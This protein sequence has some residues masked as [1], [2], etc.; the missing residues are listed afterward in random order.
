MSLTI[1]NNYAEAPYSEKTCRREVRY[2]SGDMNG[3]ARKYS[4]LPL[5]IDTTVTKRR[6]S[7]QGR[8]DTFQIENRLSRGHCRMAI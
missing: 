8:H 6:E 3:E 4:Y 1:T 5:D 2:S 7:A